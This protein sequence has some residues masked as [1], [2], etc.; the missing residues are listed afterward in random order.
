M[1]PTSGA[2]LTVVVVSCALLGVAG[3]SESPT[4]AGFHMGQIH[5]CTNVETSGGSKQDDYT[6]S[7]GQCG[8]PVDKYGNGPAINVQVLAKGDV[9]DQRRYIKQNTWA[10]HCYIGGIPQLAQVNSGPTRSLDGVTPHGLRSRLLPRRSA[11]LR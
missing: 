3:C 4:S 8:L 6:I 10:D 5:G 1:G 7:E 11:P 2:R 9:A